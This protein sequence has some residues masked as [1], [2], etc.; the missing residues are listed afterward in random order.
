MSI[1]CLSHFHPIY[2]SVSDKS[3]W[4]LA[5]SL[6]KRCLTTA[7]LTQPSLHTFYLYVNECIHAFASCVCLNRIS[8]TPMLV[9]MFYTLFVYLHTDK[10]CVMKIVTYLEKAL[11]AIVG[12]SFAL[13]VPASNIR[14]QSLFFMLLLLTTI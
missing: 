6:I 8:G 2:F 7:F 3:P 14:K 4:D 9:N 10:M 5:T 11:F 1:S 12:I 13:T